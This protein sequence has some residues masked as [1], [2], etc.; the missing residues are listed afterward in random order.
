[1]DRDTFL[2]SFVWLDIYIHSLLHVAAT[3]G[4]SSRRNF[5]LAFV[6]YRAHGQKYILSFFCLVG[7]IHPFS[8]SCMCGIYYA[9]I[10]LVVH[11]NIK[12]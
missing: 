3:S 2:V 8:S 7:Y 11:F 10:I 6:R 4:T 12:F 5:V 9:Y 1:M